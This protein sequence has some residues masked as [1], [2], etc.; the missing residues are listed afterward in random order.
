MNRKDFIKT[1]LIMGAGCSLLPSFSLGAFQEEFTRNQLIGK[2]NPDISGDSYTSTMHRETAQ[3]LKKMS[4]AAATEGI[5]I[6]V[7]SAYRSFDRQK[8]I[9]EGKYK[10]FTGQGLSPME[11]IEKIIEYSTIPG[12]SRHHWGTDLDLIDANAPR[13]ESVLQAQHY[14]GKGPFCKF[15]EWMDKHAESFGFYEVYTDN[16]NR[17]GFEYEPWHF[18]YAPVSIPM[19]KAYEKLDVKAILQEESIMG[20]EHFTD[21]F[22]TKY[23]KENILDINPKLLS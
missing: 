5:K 12:T 15:K 18:S 9:F 14:H 4:T 16:A 23:R 19:L 3:A 11:A 7:V 1:S 10:R 2:G 6:E 21:E 22:I 17:K 8:Q 13:P 20:H